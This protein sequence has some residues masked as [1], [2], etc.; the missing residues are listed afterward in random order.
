MTE[1]TV[2]LTGENPLIDLKEKQDDK[3][4]STTCSFWRLL[5]C[6]NGP[7]NIL[8][9]KSELTGGQW[10]I[11]ADNIA[12]CRWLQRTVQGSMTKELGDT[13]LPVIE[14]TFPEPIN[15]FPAFYTQ[16]VTTASETIS[17]TWSEMGD[18][19]NIKMDARPG[20]S[21]YG[22]TST[23]V[24]AGEA[25]LTVNGVQ[26]KGKAW[27]TAP[28]RGPPGST[29]FLAFSETWTGPKDGAKL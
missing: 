5:F 15:N 24:P 10:K 20:K 16:N 12:A 2:L 26:A 14:A 18:P 8:Y 29:S 25:R 19:N 4:S 21:P 28:K 23:I 22:V 11:Y 6:P 17:M 7:A 1:S 27:A 9:L 3:V 13:A